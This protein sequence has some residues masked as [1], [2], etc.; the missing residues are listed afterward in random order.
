MEILESRHKQCLPNEKGKNQS[1]SSTPTTLT[2]DV[3]TR[4]VNSVT[5]QNCHYNKYLGYLSSRL[6]YDMSNTLTIDTGI[7]TGDKK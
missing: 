6:E 2:R 7:G 4:L 3:T 5:L 1:E